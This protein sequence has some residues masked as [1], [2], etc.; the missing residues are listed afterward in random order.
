MRSVK[1][2]K[3]DIEGLQEELKIVQNNCTHDKIV[4]EYESCTGNYDPSCDTYWVSIICLCCEQR[5]SYGSN[6][7]GY[8]KFQEKLGKVLC[9][10]REDY[11]VAKR[12]G[13]LK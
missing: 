12:N 7:E 11:L 2:I 6:E 4:Y 9:I 8:S 5:F 1:E 3:R 10:K 13:L